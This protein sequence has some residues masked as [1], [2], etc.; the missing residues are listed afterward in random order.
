MRYSLLLTALFLWSANASRAQ[1]FSPGT[2]AEIYGSLAQLNQLTHVLYVAAHPDD[3]NT[4][5]LAWLEG[6]RHIP[7][8]YLSLT[9]GDGGQNILGSEQGAALGMIR[10]QELLAARRIDGARQAFTRAIDFGYSKTSRETLQNWD[11]LQILHDM[12]WVIRQLRPD[13]MICRF[14]PTAEAGHGHHASS[15]ILA[16]MAYHM[17][18]DPKAFPDQPFEAW[19]PYRLL[20]N[21][22]RFGS[23]NTTRE[24][25]FK[26]EI[27]DFL[28][29]KGMG[30]GELAGI[31]RSIHRS[32]GAG[33]PSVAGKQ[34]EHFRVWEGP[35]LN[36]DLFEG[37]ETTWARAKAPGIT[38]LVD[39]LLGQFDFEDPSA[40]LP[41]LIR[42]RAK[43]RQEARGFWRE[44]KL[45]DLDQL[46]LQ[47]AGLM[48]V[49]HHSQ[50]EVQAGQTIEV[51]FEMVSR[52]PYP[53]KWIAMDWMGEK[54]TLEQPLGYDSLVR[55]TSSLPLPDS[56][57]PTQPY[58]LQ[59]PA[60]DPFHYS[61]PR[62]EWTGLPE[63]PS[64]LQA[65]LEFSILGETFHLNLPLSYKTLDPLYGDRIEPLRLTP[66]YTL[67]FRHEK[68]WFSPGDSL[69]TEIILRAHRP[70]DKGRL[71][72][73]LQGEPLAELEINGLAADR[74]TL[75]RIGIPQRYSGPLAE[76]GQWEAYLE[77]EGRPYTLSQYRVAYDHIPTQQYF[78]PATQRWIPLP[79]QT[80]IKR[81]A[82]IPGAGDQ[83]AEIL[84]VAG[85]TVDYLKAD[86][87]N[88]ANLKQ[89]DA[90]LTGVR[91]INTESA[92][93]LWM[94]ELLQ[95][96]KQGGTLVMQYNTNRPLYSEVL[97]PYPLHLSRQ[98]VTEENAEVEW[99]H[100]DHPLLRFPYPLKETDFQ[101]WVQE[102][103]LYFPDQWDTQYQ[104]L[105]RMGDQGEPLQEGALLYT[106][107]GKGHYIY[108]GLSFF[109]Q[110]PA[111]QAGAM[112]LLINLLSA[113]KNP[114]LHER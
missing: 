63:T 64:P 93:G 21:G 28:P 62:T 29:H 105:F 43:I 55:W 90:V 10:T 23:R 27:G 4:R 35:A 33:T 109:R 37:L 94:G 102:R 107:Y 58:W 8:T 36:Q 79:R 82:Y 39:S 38:L 96:V 89:Y 18:A 70:L 3:E 44:Q 49:A 68:I 24:D 22:Y 71:V 20:F 113:G 92:S 41:G 2:S 66:D 99:I 61:I 11:S 86:Q 15:A 77:V 30:S 91:L 53:M 47:A 78:L 60:K 65:S 106:P 12:V 85:L 1:P 69:K 51:Q 42:L 59:Q 111:G 88:L 80:A 76:A 19:K 31:S 108:T 48:A 6:S 16:R 103:G 110:L 101:G 114:D 32:Q 56:L 97:G 100:P 25:D 83:T 112:K 26:L 57:P 40:S 52:S 84:G 74:D 81:I 72:V 87:I 73:H 98:R 14:P 75:V 46:I 104:A 54:H 9:R 67:K 17:A 7:V 50:P 13:L 5:L 45:R 34:T 95:Y